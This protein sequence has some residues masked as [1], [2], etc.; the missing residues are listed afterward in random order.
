MMQWTP[1]GSNADE[2][3]AHLRTFHAVFPHVIVANGPGGYGYYFMGSDEP[4]VFDDATMRE[5]LS[6]PGILADI[7]SAYDSPEKTLDGWARR[8]PTLVRMTDDAVTAS[9]GPGPLITDDRPIPE[10]FL[11]RRVFGWSIH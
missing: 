7:S 2:F 10:Y 9:T 1:T 11:L 6:R 3:R 4:M 5:V 8:I